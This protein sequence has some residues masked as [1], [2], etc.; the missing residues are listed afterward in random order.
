MAFSRGRCLLRLL[1]EQKGWTQA[2][3]ARRTGYHPRMISHYTNDK[4]PM[5]PQVMR[6]IS[7]IL[8]CGMEDLY[9]WVWTGNAE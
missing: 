1:L 3:L 6:T 7:Y 4:K 5:P 2:E 9:E 8:E